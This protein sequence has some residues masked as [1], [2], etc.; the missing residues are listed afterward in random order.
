MG[1]PE[2]EAHV[3]R[4]IRHATRIESGDLPADTP[5]DDQQQLSGE[6]VNGLPSWFGPD[7]HPTEEAIESFLESSPPPATPD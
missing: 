3:D 2:A 4:I 6:L 7:Y 5:F 1:S